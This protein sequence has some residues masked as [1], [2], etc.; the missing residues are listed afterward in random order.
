MEDKLTGLLDRMS[1]LA[2]CYKSLIEAM[3]KVMIE[4]NNYTERLQAQLRES[5]A[6]EKKDPINL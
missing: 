4:Q 5:I 1:D 2:E 3:T 6:R